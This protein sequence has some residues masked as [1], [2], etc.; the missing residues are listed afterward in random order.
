MEQHFRKMLETEESAYDVTPDAILMNGMGPFID[1]DSLWYESF[2]VEKGRLL[3]TNFQRT[4]WVY[5][6]SP[7]NLFNWTEFYFMKSDSDLLYLNLVDSFCVLMISWVN[8]FN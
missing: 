4:N 5:L 7:F 1:S 8:I 6:L 3:E 2:T